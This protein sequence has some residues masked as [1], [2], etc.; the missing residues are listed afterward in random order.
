MFILWYRCLLVAYALITLMGLAYAGFGTSGLFAPLMTPI[1]EALWGGPM[2]PEAEP[3]ARF[4]FGIIGG[5][6]AGFGELGWFVTRHAIRRREGWAWTALLLSALIW[7]AVDS[8][9]SVWSGAAIN[10]LFNVGFLLLIVVPLI[11]IRPHLRAERA[12]EAPAAA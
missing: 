6:T 11:G 3:F 8:A 10:V 9:V 7:F 5:L 12:A 4:A 2:P 1:D